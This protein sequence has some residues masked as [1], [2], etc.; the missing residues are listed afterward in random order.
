MAPKEIQI[1]EFIPP[2]EM[3]V[4]DLLAAAIARN[5]DSSI[6]LAGL[7]SNADVVAGRA[8]VDK[9]SMVGVP[10]IITSASFRKGTK[11]PD[12]IQRDFVSCEFTTITAAPIEAVY[13]DG[14]T[15]IRRQMVSYLASKGLIPE[16]YI[17]TP[18]TSIWVTDDEADP[19]FEI[20]FLAPRGLRVSTYSNDYTDEGITYYLA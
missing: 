18:D 20:R 8:L 10:H 6:D 17:E 11:G 3:S 12:G 1:P 4:A 2:K 16:S 9:A 14:S 15:G 13:N 5:T 19:T 7:L